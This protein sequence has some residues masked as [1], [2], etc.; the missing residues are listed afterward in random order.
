[1]NWKNRDM[2]NVEPKPDYDWQ[3]W[4]VAFVIWFAYICLES[5]VLLK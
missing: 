3:P 5:W 2:K 4:I 1:M